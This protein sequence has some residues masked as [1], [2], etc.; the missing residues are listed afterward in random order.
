MGSLEIK[1]SFLDVKLFSNGFLIHKFPHGYFGFFLG[2]LEIKPSFL[3]D[4]LFSN[5]FLIHT[6][7]Y[8]Y[9]FSDCPD[10]R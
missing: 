10:T 7:S 1:P 3:D 9:L 4:K 2:S 5:G 8:G 6:F